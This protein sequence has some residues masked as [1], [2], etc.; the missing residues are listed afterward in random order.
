MQRRTLF[1]QPTQALPVAQP[2]NPLRGLTTVIATDV[3]RSVPCQKDDVLTGYLCVV[4]LRSF[5]QKAASR[6]LR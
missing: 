4:I 3:W 1:A 5:P 2:A 6:W